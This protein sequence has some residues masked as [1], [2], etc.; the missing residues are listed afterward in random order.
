MRK[1]CPVDCVLLS[2][3]N[4]RALAF[5]GSA[6]CRERKTW[7]VLVGALV[8]RGVQVYRRVCMQEGD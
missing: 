6:M 4:L 8:Y 3:H 1:L 2:A 5:V 7:R